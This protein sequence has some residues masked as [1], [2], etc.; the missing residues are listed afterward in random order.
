MYVGVKIDR[1]GVLGSFELCI[2]SRFLLSTGNLPETQR[3]ESGAAQYR[4]QCRP[5][6]RAKT[7]SSSARDGAIVLGSRGHRRYYGRNP[8]STA[9]RMLAKLIIVVFLIAIIASLFSGLFF[10]LNDSSDSRRLLSALKLRVGLSIGLIAFMVLAYLMGW[11][12][13]HGVGQ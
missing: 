4:Q 6:A 3:D 11:I 8:F 13:P 7:A 12:H 2:Q 10:L 9:V 1:F 5:Q